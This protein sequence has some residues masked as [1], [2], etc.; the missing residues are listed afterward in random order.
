MSPE[1]LLLGDPRLREPARPVGDPTDPGFRREKDRLHAALRA[2]RKRHGFGRAIAAPQ[3]GA[4]FR[5]VAADLGTGPLTLIDPEIRTRSEDTLTLWDDCMSFPELL[6]KVRRHASI[7]LSFT[8]EEGR[9]QCWEDLEAAQSELF[10]HELDHLDGVLALDRAL[11]ST[12]IIHRRVFEEDPERYLAAVDLR[13]SPQC[14]RIEFP[15][16][17]DV[18]PRALYPRTS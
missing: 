6:V 7:T 17:D 3:I 9:R 15:A 8:D 14:K 2:F 16:A 12:S 10:Q 5:F 1:V 13:P 11:D 18:A 4:P